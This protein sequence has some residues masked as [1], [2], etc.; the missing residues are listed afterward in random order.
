MKNPYIMI[1]FSRSIIRRTIMNSSTKRNRVIRCYTRRI[2]RATNF[3]VCDASSMWR[4]R[5]PSIFC[6]FVGSLGCGEVRLGSII[7]ILLYRTNGNHVIAKS[8]YILR[9]ALSI[10]ENTSSSALVPA[11]T[12]AL[13]FITTR[14]YRK[15]SIG[16]LCATPGS[17]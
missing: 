1:R 11:L 15:S 13:S 9:H 2:I 4:L 17:Y 10:L 16:L 8:T 5:F 7:S 3:I 6:R 12:F 14:S